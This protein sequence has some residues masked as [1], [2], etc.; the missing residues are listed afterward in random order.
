MLEFA[1]VLPSEIHMGDAFLIHNTNWTAQSDAEWVGSQGAY[2]VRASDNYGNTR[3]IELTE[4]SYD[5]A[6]YAQYSAV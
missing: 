5:I 3:F 2:V 6:Y 1:T 4:E